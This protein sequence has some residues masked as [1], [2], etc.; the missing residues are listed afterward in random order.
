MERYELATLSTT[1]GAAAKVSARLRD[2]CTAPEARGRLLG[3]W[4][5][6]IG[7]LNRITVLRGF[8]SAADAAAER[9]RTLSTTDPFGCGEVLTGLSLDTLLPFPGMPAVEP[10]NFGP[11]YEIRSYVLKTGGLLP[12]FEGWAEALPG[13]TKL[14]KLLLATYAV[15]GPPRIVHIWPW[16]SLEERSRIRA[17]SVRIGV[18]PPK[19]AVWLTPT[20]ES[21]IGI[22]LDV[23]PLT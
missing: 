23:S 22:P 5:S 3:C 2:F 8:D 17:E 13:R 6:D 15:D 1:M 20:M 18:W 10:G 11:I 14:S 21:T 9:M 12:T 19:S 16:A 7:D 4:N